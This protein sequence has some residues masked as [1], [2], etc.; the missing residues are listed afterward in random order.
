ML[1]ENF[2]DFVNSYRVEEAKRR[3]TDPSSRYLT[4]VAIA[5]EAG[6]NSKPAFYAFG[7]RLGNLALRDHNIIGIER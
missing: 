7:G 1:F 3:L 6:F 2:F 5:Q 4:T